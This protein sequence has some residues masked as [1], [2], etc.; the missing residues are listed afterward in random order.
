MAA[1]HLGPGSH[2]EKYKMS[3]GVGRG[4]GLQRGAKG[5]PLGNDSELSESLFRDFNGMLGFTSLSELRSLS[6]GH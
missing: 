6:L 5:C 2:L 3:L 1:R 4:N